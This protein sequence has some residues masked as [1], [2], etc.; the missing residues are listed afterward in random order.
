MERKGVHT[1]LG[2]MNREIKALN[3]I[4]LQIKAAVR[5]IRQSIE[6]YFESHREA[7][8][9]VSESLDALLADFFESRSRER[10]A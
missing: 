6:E 2:D 8:R 7:K 1:F 10:E 9:Q 4:I 3:R 5:D